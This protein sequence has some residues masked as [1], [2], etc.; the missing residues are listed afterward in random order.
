[1]NLNINQYLLFFIFKITDFTKD[2]F[3]FHYELGFISCFVK[4]NPLRTF[5]YKS[6]NIYIKVY[7]FLKVIKFNTKMFGQNISL[8]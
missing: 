7:G 1:M 6:E 8:H 5:L 3:V 4:I 2:F